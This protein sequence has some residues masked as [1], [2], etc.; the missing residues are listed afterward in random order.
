VHRASFS[1]GNAMDKLKSLHQ[2]ASTKH[3]CYLVLFIVAVFLV[4]YYLV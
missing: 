3:M 2:T 4:I 1:V